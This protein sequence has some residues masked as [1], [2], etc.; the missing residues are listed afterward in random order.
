M[1][2]G[3]VYFPNQD[4]TLTAGENTERFEGELA[5]DGKCLEINSA[6]RLRDRVLMP[7][8]ALLIW[9]STFSLGLD[10]A[11]VEILDSTGRVVARVGDEVQ[12]SAF[13]LTYEQ[14]MEHGG[15]DKISPACSG[16]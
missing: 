12:L 15:M 11:H 4:G 10:D 7:V 2:D 3:E 13:D 16:H 9:P 8:D 1:P 5:L 14:A 6:L